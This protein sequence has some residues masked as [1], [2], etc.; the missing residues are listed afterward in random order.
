MKIM[1]LTATQAAK[2]LN[3]SLETIY[4]MCKDGR[5]GGR[6]SRGTGKTKG[7]W[8]IDK[9]SLELFEE[10]TTFKSIYQEK[11]ESGQRKLF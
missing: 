4:N 8:M 1:W 9:E 10:V 6:Y 5:L 3:V 11:K 2:R 7:S